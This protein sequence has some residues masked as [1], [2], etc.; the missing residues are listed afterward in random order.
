MAEAKPFVPVKYICG[1]IASRDSI[2]K[3]AESRLCPLLGTVDSRSP[4][5]DFNLTRYYESQ[6]GKDLKRGFLS[7]ATL[8]RP[9]RLAEIKLETNKLEERMSLEIKSS[10]RVVNLDPGYLTRSGLIMATAKDFSHRIPLQNGIY[11]HLE[12]LFSKSKL[13]ILEWTYPDFQR[14]DYQR[15]FLEVR[16]I[17]LKQLKEYPADDE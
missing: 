6:M 12:L 17:Y 5:F 10:I 7:F 9:E 16:G 15:F 3:E 11:A 14:E 13:R 4:L 1:I 2:F 8:Q